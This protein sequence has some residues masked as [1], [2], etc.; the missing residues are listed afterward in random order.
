M[1]LW[2]RNACMTRA[3]LAR[4]LL[5]NA[6]L[7]SALLVSPLLLRP[8]D[9][10]PLLERPF[11]DVKGSSLLTIPASEVS[12]QARDPLGGQERKEQ[13]TSEKRGASCSFT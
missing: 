5:D 2:S 6:A 10:R 7:A 13:K 4:E 3:L 8:F 11:S 9:E 1:P 12:V